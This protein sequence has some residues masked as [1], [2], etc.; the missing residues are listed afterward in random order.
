[1]RRRFSRNLRAGGADLARR[2]SVGVLFNTARRTASTPL[3]CTPAHS[4]RPCIL[5]SLERDARTTQSG[6]HLGMSHARRGCSFWTMAF[7]ERCARPCPRLAPTS[8]RSSGRSGNP[9]V[10]GGPG[11]CPGLLV[12]SFVFGN[13][14]GA[15]RPLLREHPYVS[16]VSLRRGSAGDYGSDRIMRIPSCRGFEIAKCA[17]TS[18]SGLPVGL[19]SRNTT[20]LPQYLARRRSGPLRDRSPRR[21]A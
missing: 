5:S 19:H 21:R 15:V 9:E 20:R 2:R 4:G 11:T 7:F 3:R 8:Q 10:K 1:M 17:E 14:R 13:S 12:S 18:E 16:G 6:R